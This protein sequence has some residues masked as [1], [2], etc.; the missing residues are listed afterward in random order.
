MASLATS[1]TI[2]PEAI[3]DAASVATLLAAAFGGDTE[4][5]LVDRLRQDGDIVLS[6]VAEDANGIIV[7]SVTF[8]RLVIQS[9]D[10]NIPAIGLAPLAVAPNA[11]RRGIGAALVRHGLGKLGDRAEAIIFVLGDPAYY[12]RFGF[13]LAA[14]RAFECIY[15][16]PHFM[17][18]R[19]RPIAPLDGKVHYPA[20]FAALG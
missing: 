11:Q 7:G 4:A 16:G 6:L 19:M 20:A 10:R 1:P 12:G 5:N 8:L 13:D 14:A 18:H 9:G 15:A 17:A 2:R 3:G